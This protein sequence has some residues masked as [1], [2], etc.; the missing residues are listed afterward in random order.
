MTLVCDVYSQCVF[1]DVESMERAQRD[2]NETVLDGRR[3]K[4]RKVC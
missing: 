3:I 4:L 2:L 1:V